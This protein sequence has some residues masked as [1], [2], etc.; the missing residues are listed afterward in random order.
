M[1]ISRFCVVGALFKLPPAGAPL[2]KLL[3]RAV[4][5]NLIEFLL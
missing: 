3:A 5:P 2:F 4:R 1:S